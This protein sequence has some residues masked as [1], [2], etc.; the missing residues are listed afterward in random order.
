MRID[1]HGL[2]TTGEVANILKVSPVTVKRYIANEKIPSVKFNGIRRIKGVDL[3]N[4]LSGLKKSSKTKSEI[5]IK[6]NIHSK[7]YLL[8]RYW[9][10]KSADLI[11]YYI[12]KYTQPNDLIVDPFVGSGV[13]IIESCKLG[14]E[15][16]G[17]DI[18]PLSKLIT[19]GTLTNTDPIKV[20]EMIEEILSKIPQSVV[21][22]QLTRSAN[23][24]KSEIISWVWDRDELK[25]IRAFNLVD[26]EFIKTPSKE[27][28][29]VNKKAVRL[30]KKY[31]QKIEYPTDKILKFVRRSGKLTVDE[32]FSKRNLLILG[33]ISKEINKVKNKKYEIPLK[34][35]FSS[36]LVNCSLMIPADVDRVR[37]KSGWQISKLWVP[38]TH[39][40]KNVFT[41]LRKKTKD[42]IV[43]KKEI[44]PLILNLKYEIYTSNSENLSQIKDSSVDYIFTDPPY[45]DNIAYLGLN[46]FWNTWVSPKVD[47]E[48]EIIYDRTRKKGYKE[49]RDG[50]RNVYREMSRIL[51]P[52][53]YMTFTFNN[54]NLRFWKIILDA[55]LDA[56]FRLENVLW[57]D[58]A[59]GSGTQGI[60]RKNTLKGDF[61][62]TFKKSPGSSKSKDCEGRKLLLK[63]VNQLL[64]YK[65]GFAEVHEVYENL[66]PELISKR[67]FLDGGKIMDIE[68]VLS[69]NYRFSEKIAG[70]KILY[71]WS[72]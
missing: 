61:I 42:Y 37:G 7:H 44:G 50:L 46:M 39:I 63:K 13:V 4:I 16:V 5:K 38:T 23:G 22:L 68:K 28:I 8:H 17:I 24:I 9:G 31:K 55:S 29:D 43:G 3:Q 34:L 36:S 21:D 26:G 6:Q 40:E 62:Y 27:D 45:G 33:L 64:R 32:L 60:N 59:V 56:G 15:S 66:L 35:I 20:G 2:Y 53:R 58:Q 54:R 51:K 25:K 19:H 47:Y 12:K 41:T 67:A 69:E 72:K 1:K 57:I 48:N 30:L 10:R 70:S 65:R 18:N 52:G 49:Y 11:S 71:G 14:R